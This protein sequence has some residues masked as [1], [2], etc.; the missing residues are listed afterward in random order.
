M[1]SIILWKWFV[2]RT[3]L[4]KEWTLI[5]QL[6]GFCEAFWHRFSTVITLIDTTLGAVMGGMNGLLWV[7]GFKFSKLDPYKVFFFFT[8]LGER[9][10]SAPPVRSLILRAIRRIFAGRAIFLF[11]ISSTFHD[12]AS[13]SFTQTQNWYD[14]LILCVKSSQNGG[15][16]F[17][18][19]MVL[20]LVYVP[21]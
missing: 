21:T 8:K 19:I 18:V 10:E 12:E 7:I 9:K 14:L 17:S 11:D 20:L 15:Y 1:W 6:V 5:G 13:P 2:K 3:L 4:L 16:L